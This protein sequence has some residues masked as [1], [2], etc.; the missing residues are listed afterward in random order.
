M[1]LF[2]YLLI[3]MMYF[4]K[5]PLHAICDHF[6]RL[7]KIPIRLSLCSQGIYNT[8]RSLRSKLKKL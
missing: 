8:A 3:Y 7:Q 5:V 4:L 2:T 6:D 1:I